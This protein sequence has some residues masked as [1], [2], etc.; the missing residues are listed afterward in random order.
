MM[1][2]LS[3]IALKV[4]SEISNINHEKIIWKL[5]TKMMYFLDDVQKVV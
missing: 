5:Q 1:C 4:I 2:G 3:E